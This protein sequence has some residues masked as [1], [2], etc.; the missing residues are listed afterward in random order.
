MNVFGVRTETHSSLV[1]AKP[2]GW[3]VYSD[4]EAVS[5]PAVVQELPGEI[6]YGRTFTDASVETTITILVADANRTE[7]IKQLYSGLDWVHG[8]LRRQIQT[9]SAAQSSAIG[10]TPTL[11]LTI[12]FTQQDITK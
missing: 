3:N 6:N 10:S 1:A 7:A 2:T 5:L 9:V 11:Q 4:G 8:V 12:N